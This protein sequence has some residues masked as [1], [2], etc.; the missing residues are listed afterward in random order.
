[1]RHFCYEPLSAGS[2]GLCQP[3]SI[4]LFGLLNQASMVLL[5]HYLTRSRS[6]VLPVFTGTLAAAAADLSNEFP[7]FPGDFESS[8]PVVSSSTGH[9][10]TIGIREKSLEPMREMNVRKL[11]LDISFGENGVRFTGNGKVYH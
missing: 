11:V 1:M 3:I 8:K 2:T 5:A 9:H 10:P 7:A 6:I 4:G